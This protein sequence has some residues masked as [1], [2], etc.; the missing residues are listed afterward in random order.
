VQLFFGL[1]EPISGMDYRVFKG[2]AQSL[3]HGV[4]PYD[5]TNIK[6]YVGGTIPFNYPP[7]TLLFFWC[8]Q[9]LFVYQNIWIYYA[10][11]VTFLAAGG[12][13]IAITDN[14]PQYLFLIT[15]L[16]TA[17]ISMFWNFYNGNK[18]IF[19]L[20]L[21]AGIFYLL[22][23]E[24][25]WHSSIVLGLLGSVTLVHLPFVALSLAIQRPLL[26]RLQY[27]LMSIG[28]VAALFLIT[29]L[30][31]PSAMV[32]YIK[33]FEGSSSALN[34]PSGIYN[35]TPFLMFGV[36][37]HQTNGITPQLILVSLVYAG[38]VIGACWY[39]IKKN[40]ENPL[41]LYSITM[42]AIFMILPRVKPYY[43]IVLAIPLYFLFRDCSDKIKILVLAV[44]SLLPLSVWYHFWI[45]HTQPISYLT[46]LI[47][48][49]TQIFSLFLIFIIAVTLAYYRPVS[50]PASHIRDLER[51]GEK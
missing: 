46:Y 11:L 37:L 23:K 40:R 47:L 3:N 2:A 16:L 44:V 51:N 17:F 18:E 5:L 34:E 7:H 39:V 26:Q 21:F 20:F 45:D 6:Y 24:K 41:I 25:F 36:L 43:F 27:V 29:W 49:Y 31:N 50:S 35:P 15:L 22:V 32:S 19:N 28:V 42:L 38:L 4:D 48:S 8:L 10:I 33:T 1:S 30:I 14:K 13:L 12:Y 9:F